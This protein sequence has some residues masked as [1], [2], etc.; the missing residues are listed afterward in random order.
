MFCSFGR[1]RGGAAKVVVTFLDACYRI[2]SPGSL[3][4]SRQRSCRYEYKLAKGGRFIVSRDSARYESHLASN[5]RKLSCADTVQH[6]ES[7]NATHHSI[8]ICT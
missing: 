5:F 6:S 4:G 2:N 3:W 1:G 7:S 8:T